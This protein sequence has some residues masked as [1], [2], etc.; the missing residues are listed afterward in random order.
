MNKTSPRPVSAQ[1][2]AGALLAG[3]IV[4]AAILLP[5]LQAAARIMA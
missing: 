3:L 2:H 5:F 1:L 4:V